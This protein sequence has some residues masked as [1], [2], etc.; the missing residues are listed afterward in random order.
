MA[1]EKK[2]KTLTEQ[3]NDPM[4]QAI[5]GL[6]IFSPDAR[7]LTP[8]KTWE[9]LQKAKQKKE[10]DEELEKAIEAASDNINL[11]SEKEK[12]NILELA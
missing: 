10:E 7:G 3:L 6:N 12:K 9:K 1:E 4:F 8:T 5:G 2:K 11:Q